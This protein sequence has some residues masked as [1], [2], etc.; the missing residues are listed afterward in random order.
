MERHKQFK[1]KE[2]QFTVSITNTGEFRPKSIIDNESGLFITLKCKNNI[3][4]KI[5]MNIYTSNG[6]STYINKTTGNVRREKAYQQRI[7]NTLPLWTLNISR[8]HRTLKDIKYV[9]LQ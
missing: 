2:A 6:A 3:A 7:F 4:D 5:V 9:W 1:Q 8:K